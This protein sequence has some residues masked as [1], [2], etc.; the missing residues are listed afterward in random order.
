V[1]ERGAVAE[2]SMLGHTMTTTFDP[3]LANPIA[4]MRVEAILA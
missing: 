3:S 1:N 4:I 2:L